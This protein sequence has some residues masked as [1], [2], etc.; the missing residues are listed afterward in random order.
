MTSVPTA[1][2][3]TVPIGRVPFWARVLG[4][5]GFRSV[6][7]DPDIDHGS[8]HHFCAHT[9]IAPPMQPADI[10]KKRPKDREREKNGPLESAQ[11]ISERDRQGRGHDGPK[12]RKYK[13]EQIPLP[14]WVT[15]V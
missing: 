15:H 10:G 13:S 7:L 1:I 11:F 9:A 5:P 14:V 2:A 4:G 8:V 12:N 3:V 6:Q